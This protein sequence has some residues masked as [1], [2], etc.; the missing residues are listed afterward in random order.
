LVAP[1][2]KA[3]QRRLR[4]GEPI[5]GLVDGAVAAEGHDDVVSLARRLAADLGGVIALLGVD[6]LD[7]VARLQRVDD[8]V[9]QPVRHRGRV[10]V[11]DHQH[12]LLGCALGQQALGERLGAL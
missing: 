8:E 6:G 12:A 10:R 2:G 3:R 5:G 7:C 11:D 1:P 4:S 9:A